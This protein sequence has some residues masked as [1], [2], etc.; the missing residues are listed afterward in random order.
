MSRRRRSRQFLPGAVMSSSQPVPWT[1]AARRPWMPVRM[2]RE[3]RTHLARTTHVVYRTRGRPSRP[4][5][6]PR[7]RNRGRP[8]AS[9]SLATRPRLWGCGPAGRRRV[10]TLTS[11]LISGAADG[12]SSPTLRPKCTQPATIRTQTPWS[13]A[14]PPGW[15]LMARAAGT[16]TVRG[17][18]SDTTASRFGAWAGHRPD[19]RNP[20]G[21]ASSGNA[22]PVSTATAHAGRMRMMLCCCLAPLRG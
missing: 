3:P 8:R 14:R 19:P 9:R 16:A 21:P 13:P 12:N 22:H 2:P 11:A 18:Q 6:R 15:R 7:R 1:T 5:P 4:A 10:G 20:T 17:R